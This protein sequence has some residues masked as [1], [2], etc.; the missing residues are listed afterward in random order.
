MHVFKSITEN[1]A[2]TKIYICPLSVLII[3]RVKLK[4]LVIEMHRKSLQRCLLAEELK[5]DGIS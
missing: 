5:W 2:L 4:S 1:T 3:S